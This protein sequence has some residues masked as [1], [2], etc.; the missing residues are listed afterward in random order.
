MDKYIQSPEGI[1]RRYVKRTVVAEAIQ[2]FGPGD[3]PLVLEHRPMMA[4]NEG[5]TLYTVRDAERPATGWL[6]IKTFAHEPHNNQG[7]PMRFL[8]DDTNQYHWRL[9][10][11]GVPD[12]RTVF[13]PLSRHTLEYRDFSQAMKWDQSLQYGELGLPDAANPSRKRVVFVKT[14]DWIVHGATGLSVYSAADFA[15]AFEKM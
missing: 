13:T 14:G 11:S 9:F 15:N 5:G 1:G 12:L 8:G 3:H 6:T 2:W 10:Y 7:R 4:L